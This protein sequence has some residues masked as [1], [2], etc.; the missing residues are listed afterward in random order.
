M[1]EK[2]FLGRDEVVKLGRNPASKHFFQHVLDE[3]IS[4]MEI[5]FIISWNMIQ[6][7][8]PSEIITGFINDMNPIP[9]T[10]IADTLRSPNQTI[11]EA[12]L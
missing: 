11:Y 1:S 8:L 6:L 10:K 7:F 12:Y 5:I 2:Q 9:T 4:N 3:N